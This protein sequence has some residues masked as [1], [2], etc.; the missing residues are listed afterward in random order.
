MTCRRVSRETVRLWLQPSISCWRVEPWPRIV[1]KRTNGGAGQK[2]WKKYQKRK[3]A[4]IP[5]WLQLRRKLTSIWCPCIQPCSQLLRISYF[6]C[7]F[8]ISAPRLVRLCLSYS[9]YCIFEF[10]G[11]SAHSRI[12]I[13]YLFSPEKKKKRIAAVLAESIPDFPH[14]FSLTLPIF[15]P[16]MLSHLCN[17]IIS[18]HD[19]ISTTT[20]N[21]TTLFHPFSHCY[22]IFLPRYTF[23]KFNNPLPS[24]L[25]TN[26]SL[27]LP[28]FFSIFYFTCIVTESTIYLFIYLS[29][30]MVYNW[31]LWLYN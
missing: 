22:V 16:N 21:K 12:E 1:S 20:I 15:F 13:L 14:I 2:S 23:Q 19:S 27:Y 24:L 30:Y 11:S 4:S 25:P 28:T 10:E 5:A 18:P 17:Y 3:R 26:L 31:L 29:N 8:I 6:D 9:A 7:V